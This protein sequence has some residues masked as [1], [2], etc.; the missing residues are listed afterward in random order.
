MRNPLKRGLAE[1]VV[2]TPF[3]LSEAVPAGRRRFWKQVLPVTTINY[4]GHKVKF[5]KRFH[6]DLAQSFKDE[7]F[8]QVPVVFATPENA[9]NMDPRNF[10]GDVLDMQVRP[11]GLFALI[12]ADETAA[13]A[14]EK[15]PK[16]GV[17]ARIRQGLEKSDGRKFDRAIE[18]ICLTMNPRVTG[19]EPW[20]AVDLSD[21]DADIE[22]VDLTAENYGKE[23]DMGVRRTAKKAASSKKAKGPIDLS[24]LSDE[25]FQN[26]LDLAETLTADPED[27]DEVELDE[28]GNPIEDEVEDEPVRK[29]RRKKSKT[30]ITVEKDSEDE[31][32]E[33]DD[34]D[35]PDADLSDDDADNVIRAG[36]RSQF[37]QMRYDLA[38][39]DWRTERATL[40]AAGVPPFMLDL[41][42]PFLSLPDAVVIDL[43]DDEDP[44]DATEAMRKMLDGIRGVVDLTGEMGHQIDLTS[45]ED[46]DAADAFNEAWDKQYG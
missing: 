42:E 15:N 32:D 28:D 10:G 21:E 26:L 1:Q 14:I 11:K 4:K 30:K 12:E 24:A 5:D 6:M 33:G 18:H 36:E 31:G 25:Q 19:M 34:L 16:L 35:D 7:A 43:S 39:R 27:L 37:Q 45:D 29:V 44:L 17:S 9:H 23:E 46:S 20:Q 22:V 13:K 38:E 2:Y 8:D 40:T 41:A 3:D